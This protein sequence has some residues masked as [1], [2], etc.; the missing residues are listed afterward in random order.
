MVQIRVNFDA[1]TNA[2]NIGKTARFNNAKFA[3][4][5]DEKHH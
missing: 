3:V 4:I 5:L 2:K 1:A